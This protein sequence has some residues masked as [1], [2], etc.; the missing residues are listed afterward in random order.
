METLNLT[1]QEFRSGGGGEVSQSVEPARQ[2]DA[3]DAGSRL[4]SFSVKG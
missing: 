3:T 1:G 2:R 4:A